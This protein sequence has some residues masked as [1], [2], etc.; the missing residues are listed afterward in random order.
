MLANTRFNRE[1]KKS[2]RRKFK[3]RGKQSVKS[4][5]NEEEEQQSAKIL[6]EGECRK[7]C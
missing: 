1:Q 5:D 4:R 7:R 6:D 2:T 3:L